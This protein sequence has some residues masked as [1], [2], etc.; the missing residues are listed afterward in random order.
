[1]RTEWADKTSDDTSTRAEDFSDAV[2]VEF[3]AQSASSVPSV[4]MGQADGGV[5]IWQWRADSDKGVASPA[6]AYTNALIDSYPSDEP[7]FFT[8]RAAGNPIANSAETGPVQTLVAQLFGTLSPA[9]TQNAQ[10]KGV[11]DDGRWAVVFSREFE[12][13]DPEQAVFEVGT[14][15]DIAFAV[16]DGSNDER[17]G[18]KSVSGFVK[19]FVSPDS[20]QTASSLPRPLFLAVV[21][22]ATGALTWLGIAYARE[23]RRQQGTATE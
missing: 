9:S 4:C 18:R 23:N 12:S 7:V 1:V 10:G 14:A 20:V 17:N 2:A 22:A 16:W 3:P 21:L 13:A 15:T 8:A 19:L 5:N 6:E 11:H